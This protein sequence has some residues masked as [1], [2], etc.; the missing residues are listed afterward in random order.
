MAA[1]LPETT[2][3]YIV[4]GFAQGIGTIAAYALVLWLL[5]KVEEKQP[6]LKAQIVD[7]VPQLTY[8][9]CS[10]RVVS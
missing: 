9:T 10:S 4:R 5:S 7:G 2:G 8:P 3:G 6:P 1:E